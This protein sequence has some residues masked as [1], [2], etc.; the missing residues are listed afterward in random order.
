ML[1]EFEAD[2]TKNIRWVFIHAVNP[3]GF[4]RIRRFNEENVDLNRN[5][6][7]DNAQY[8]GSPAGYRRLNGFLNPATEPSRYEPF[9]I[10]ATWNILRYGQDALKQ[11]IAVGQYDYPQ[12]IFY[13]GSGPSQ[14]MEVIRSNGEQWIGSAQKV[15]HVDFHSGLGSFGV[16]KLLLAELAGTE[17]CQWYERV[18]GQDSVEATSEVAG[19]AYRATGSMGEWLQHHFAARDYRFVTAEFGTYS[20]VRVLASIRAENQ[21][22]HFGTESSQAYRNAKQELLECFC[23]ADRSWRRKV[24][25][26]GLRILRQ[27]FNGL[28][29][30]QA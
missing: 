29:D 27:G 24:L 12:G 11:S 14:A 13:G 4:S 7:T 20:P 21:A 5:F 23:P 16:Y 18:F 8:T 17:Q 28:C 10:K 15:L 22:H 6:L 2:T 25:T 30:N 9:R 1:S 19:T 3:F 26:S